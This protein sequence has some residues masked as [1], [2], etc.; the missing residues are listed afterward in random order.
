MYGDNLI[1]AQE[2]IMTTVTNIERTEVEKN[3]KLLKTWRATL[4]SI[5]SNA[6]NGENLGTNL[7]SHSRV[8][9]FKNGI[10]LVEADH[11]AWIQTLRIY[12]KYILIGL[13]RG[14]PD[15]KIS[16]L[17]FRLR[18]TK[19]ELHNQISEEKIRDEIKSKVER[20]DEIIQKFDANREN[21]T[22]HNETNLSEKREMPE[23][24]RKILDRLKKD[25]MEEEKK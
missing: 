19:V 22:L 12:Q 2:M 15:V 17:A 8:I 14:V 16:S 23:N 20:D 6:K 9:D 11:P 13:K 21:S 24:L 3:N 25:M 7:F 18:G 5:R 4:E 1:S 10:L